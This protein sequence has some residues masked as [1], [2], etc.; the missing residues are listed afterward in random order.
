MKLPRIVIQ[1]SS[2]D[3]GEASIRL[4][5]KLGYSF[6]DLDCEETIQMYKNKPYMDSSGK[7]C[8]RNLI[9]KKIY[10]KFEILIGGAFL[11]GSTKSIRFSSLDKFLKSNLNFPINKYE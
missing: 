7:I 3:E 5:Y 8:Y 2:Y 11:Y 1:I 4:F 6:D 10:N 9:L